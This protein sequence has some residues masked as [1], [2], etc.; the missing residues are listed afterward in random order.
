MG[1]A[2]IVIG[3]ILLALSVLMVVVILQQTGKE[4]GLSGSISGGSSDT[5]FGKSGGS[6]KEKLLFRVTVVASVLFVALAV[7]LT[8]LV[9]A[10]K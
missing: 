7:T 1:V 6:T 9:L 5:Y 10:A 8:I 3:A 4:K 2:E